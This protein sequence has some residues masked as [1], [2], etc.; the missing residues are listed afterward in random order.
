MRELGTES[1]EACGHRMGTTRRR[2]GGRVGAASLV[3]M[4]VASAA[5]VRTTV[6]RAALVTM[7]AVTALVMMAVVAGCGGGD[8]SDGEDG[9]HVGLVFDVGGLGDKSFNDLAY[10]GLVR[11]REDFGISFEYFEP[12]Q[13]SERESALRLFAQGDA[14]LIIGV[15]FLFSDDIRA[16]AEDFHAKHFVCID[17]TWSPGD[18][19]PPNLRGI[20]FRE[21]EGSFLVGALAAM[22][23]ETGVLGF[24]GGMDIPLIHKFEAGFRAGAQH[25][26]S[27]V[28]VL[29]NYAGVTGEAF[30]NPSKGKE[31][32]LSQY[33][34]GADIIFHASGST[35]LGVFE[36][37]REKN[38]LAIGVD[39]DQSAEAP[40]RILTSMVK[41]VDVTV[42]E[43][44]RRLH[45]GSFEGGVEVMGL[46]EGA[47]G[48]VRDE[49]NESFFTPGITDTLAAL[50]EGILAGRIEVP[51]E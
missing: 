20:K 5:L 24:I 27:D 13:S 49:T 22:V 25:V 43:Q 2:E 26:R 8:E 17:Y 23:S 1:N 6:A 42:Y 16:V 14:D 47:V 50:R 39:S 4:T 18:S 48:Y 35:G 29:V 3:R 31:L 12:T 51:S 28:R 19:I 36:A 9:L 10:A 7:L 11:A 40:G 44:I 32:A 46:A 33:E 38:E 45:S 21:E 30:K 34:Q 41:N 15:G 37:A